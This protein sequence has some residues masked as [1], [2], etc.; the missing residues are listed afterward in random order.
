MTMEQSIAMRSL[1][2]A[3]TSL[4]GTAKHTLLSTTL[5]GARTAQKPA[6]PVHAGA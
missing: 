5:Q 1:E 4:K 2:V 3:T 6:A